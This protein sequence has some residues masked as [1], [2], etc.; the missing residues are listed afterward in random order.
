M[1]NIS[2]GKLLNKNFLVRTISGAIY[3]SLI[4][5]ALLVQT[6]WLLFSLFLF[7]TVAGIIEYNL[8][9][10]VN[11][12]RTFTT[13]LDCCAGVWLLYA[14]MQYGSGTFGTEVFTPYAA[15]LL[16]VLARS[17]FHEPNN[18]YRNVGNSLISQLLIALPFSLGGYMTVKNGEFNGTFLLGLYLLTWINDTGAYIVGVSFG[19]HKMIPS[20]SPKKS[21][22]GLL[23]GIVF[24]VV[25][26]A[27][28][29]SF[30][31]TYRVQSPWFMSLFGVAIASMATIGDLFES[32]LKR[33]AG[34]KDSGSII[35]GHGGI[36]DRSDSLLFVIPTAFVLMEIFW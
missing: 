21:Y 3:V 22:E 4:L 6:Q 23:G 5:G 10:K 17:V 36:L 20:I 8:L 35:P 24:T 2:M 11:R 7:C 32:V 16:Y 30:L 25:L 27:F 13:V 1:T 28:L 26:A 12:D 9:S 14:S 18:L 31:E 34:V 33:N 19:K 29:P 15:Y